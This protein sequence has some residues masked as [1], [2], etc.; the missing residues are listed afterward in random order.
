MTT[1]QAMTAPPA[2]MTDDEPR[3][4]FRDLLAAEWLKTWSLRS[5]SW[6]YAIT[7]LAVIGFNAGTAYDHY[8]YWYQYDDRGRASFVANGSPLMDAFTGNAA[9]V[10][11]LA[12]AAI[13]AV[14]IT[15]EYGTGLIRTTFTAVPARRSVMAAKALV[16]TAVTT[17]FGAL[18]ALA[19]FVS[20]Q[21][22][23]SGRD[24]SVT[25]GHPGALRLVVASA[26]LAPVAALAGLAIGAVIRHTGGAVIGCVV[27]L[28]LLPM[29]LSDR[30]HLTAVLQHT[31]PFSAWER[32]SAS[33]LHAPVLYPW[34][35][36]GAWTVYV[37][38]ALL[39]GVVATVAVHRRDQ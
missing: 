1:A 3:A 38:W 5:T 31:L 10:L 21:A 13:G 7:A 9:M 26:L 20:T 34:T 2:R 39:A 19:S 16:L 36:S 4:R 24:A 28:L 17:L 33:D 37:A 6:M 29:V 15:G 35:V 8:K 11:V 25:L 32:L 30:R 18:V 14:S 22:I 12:V 23:L 27:V